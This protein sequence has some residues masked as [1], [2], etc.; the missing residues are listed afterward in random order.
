MSRVRLE[1]CLRAGVHVRGQPNWRFVKLHT[2]GCHDANIEAWLG[3]EMGQ[4]HMDLRAMAAESERLRFHYV[5]AWEMAQLVHQAEAGASEP[6]LGAA[7]PSLKLDSRE[8]A[9]I[10]NPV[11][12]G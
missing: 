8:R 7:V 1:Q 4:F 10:V 5:T 6:R 11:H 3:D 12:K 2:H 9:S